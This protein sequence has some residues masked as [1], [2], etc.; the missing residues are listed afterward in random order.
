MNWKTY[1]KEDGESQKQILTFEYG[2][3]FEKNRL[4]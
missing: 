1:I 2:W 4:F 3:I